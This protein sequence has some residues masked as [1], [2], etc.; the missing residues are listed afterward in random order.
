MQNKKTN[1]SPVIE[2]RKARH[3]Y[4]IEDSI[5]VGIVLKG[6]EVKSVRNGQASLA[7]GWIRATERPLQLTL[8]GVHISRISK[9]IIVASARTSSHPNPFS[10]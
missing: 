8:H 1:N 7:E 4:H 9:C 10:T 5:E 3:E 6:T 2:N